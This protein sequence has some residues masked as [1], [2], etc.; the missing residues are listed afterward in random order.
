MQFK[1][2]FLA[3]LALVMQELGITSSDELEICIGG[4]SIY[5]GVVARRKHGFIILRRPSTVVLTKSSND[6]T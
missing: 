5:E 3:R 2:E 4:K 1:E 6:D